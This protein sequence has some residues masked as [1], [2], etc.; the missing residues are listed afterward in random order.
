MYIPESSLGADFIRA[1]IP[2]PGY[3]A[4][5]DLLEEGAHLNGIK[6]NT[7]IAGGTTDHISFLE[8][9]SGLRDR[10]G[11]WLGCPRWLGCHKRGKRKI[12]ASALVALL[13][14]KASP[15]VF[16]G[17]IHTPN[18]TADRVYPG[19][20]A[21]SLRIIDYWYFQM[22]GGT[23]I[24]EPRDLSEYHY[25]QLFRVRP[26]GNPESQPEEW[27]L[28][29]K[30]AVE[31]NRR[32]INGLYR[33]RAEISTGRARCRDLEILDWGVHTRL[34][35]EVEGQL[36]RSSGNG[37]ARGCY[38]RV[39]VEEIEVATP[40]GAMLFSGRSR[41]VFSALHAL[42]RQALGSF[43]RFMG[44]NTFLT[45]FV[46]AYLLARVFDTALVFVF[47]HLPGFAEWF[48]DW[49]ALMLPLTVAVQL[50]VLLWL[51]GSK[52]P[53]MI[54]NAYRHL[55]KADNLRSLRRRG[56]AGG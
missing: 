9:N 3:R 21:E 37:A 56:S 28:A 30:D 50:A 39:P 32:N 17:K 13:S 46:V 29:M 49:F 42:G 26:K 55:N 38:E 4:L 31:P 43:E 33:V 54:D 1:F 2:L 19:P 25:A 16:G 22:H 52:I 8:V 27:W 6:Y 35:H 45:F 44:S 7:F 47:G 10:L 14:G 34:H 23:R 12:P 20:L 36:A 48:F 11:D 41:N 40:G 51:I 5:N 15:L 24:S 53:T 18:D